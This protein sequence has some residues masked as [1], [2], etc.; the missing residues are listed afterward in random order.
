MKLL[1]ILVL[2]IFVCGCADE[3]LPVVDFEGMS[4]GE[5]ISYY[6]SAPKG[7]FTEGSIR[8]FDSAASE[9]EAREILEDMYNSEYNTVNRIEKAS[10]NDGYFLFDVGWI[11]MKSGR[12]YSENCL[13]FKESFFDKENQKFGAVSAEVIKEVFDIDI[14]EGICNTGGSK[15]LE[16]TVVKEGAEYVYTCYTFD[17]TYGDWGLN[18]TLY[19]RLTTAIVDANSGVVK[20][21]NETTVKNITIPGTAK[22][23]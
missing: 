12:Q 16:S 18:D 2:V 7:G 8:V 14:Y 9:D 5:I 17:V 22:D 20:D 6:D 15:M 19:L 21:V 10:E 13:V 1:K 4:N 23:M 11:Y 3:T